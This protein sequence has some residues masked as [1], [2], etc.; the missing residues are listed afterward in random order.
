MALT[1][2][3]ICDK[4]F[5][6]VPSG[7][8]PDE[9]DGFLD[10]IMDEIQRLLDENE[11]LNSK[12]ASVQQDLEMERNAAK[13]AAA[14]PAQPAPETTASTALEGILRQAQVFADKEMAEARAKAERIIQDAKDEATA[15]VDAAQQEKGLLA[16]KNESLRNSVKAYREDFLSLLKKYQNMLNEEGLFT[17]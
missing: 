9:V 3:D 13:P 15:T 4:E 17:R 1:I 10:D 2:D 6:K 11:A 12:L 14:A 7:Y 16:E 8:D 5:R